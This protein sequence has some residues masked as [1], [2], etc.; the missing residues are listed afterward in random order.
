MKSVKQIWFRN[1]ANA[2]A[3]VVF[4]DNASENFL[5]KLT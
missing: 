5:R 3:G 1:A 4:A 2:Q